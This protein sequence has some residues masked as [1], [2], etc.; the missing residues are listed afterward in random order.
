MVELTRFKGFC[1]ALAE[2]PDF[3]FDLTFTL[4][5]FAGSAGFAL[6]ALKLLLFED[7]LEFAGS[8]SLAVPLSSVSDCKS[9]VGW[10]EV[11]SFGLTRN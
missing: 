9:T 5:A 4:E 1:T 2:S 10:S 3:V 7:G 8:S 6:D 11:L